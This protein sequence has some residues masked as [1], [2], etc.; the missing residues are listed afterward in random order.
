MNV[1]YAQNQ[2]N[3][4]FFGNEAGI[5]FSSGAPVSITTGQ[6]LSIEGCASVSDL[7]TGNLLFYSNGLQIWN[8]NHVVMPNGNGLLGG[9]STS[10]TQGVLIVPFPNNPGR[11]FLFTVDESIGGAVNGF[12]YSVVN[13]NLNGGLGD[14]VSGQKNILIQNNVSERLAVAVKG[15]STGYWVM[16][17]S[18]VIISLKRIWWIRMA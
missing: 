7:V 17:M 3:F 1:L 10:S 13:M 8:A 14:V 5:D 9:A 15:D 11:Y 4:W 18:G 16:S 6:M 2:N 12:R